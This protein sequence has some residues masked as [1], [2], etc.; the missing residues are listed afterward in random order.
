M[1]TAHGNDVRPPYLGE[2]WKRNHCDIRGAGVLSFSFPTPEPVRDACR[3]RFAIDH[4]RC[5]RRPRTAHVAAVAV[6][7][8]A[9]NLLPANLR[10]LG[11]ARSELDREGFAKLEAAPEGGLPA[12]LVEVVKQL[13]GA[14][15]Y[16][17]Y[18]LAASVETG[19]TCG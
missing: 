10:I 11:T 17:G 3:A 2:R 19:D 9:E 6:S 8:Q 15:A 16:R 12:D 1:R 4:L 5:H 14:L 18:V 13:K 7:L